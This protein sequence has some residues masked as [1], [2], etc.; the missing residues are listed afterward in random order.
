MTEMLEAPAAGAREPIAPVAT[1]TWTGEFKALLALG[2][3]LIISQLAQN[4]LHTTD[5]DVGLNRMWLDEAFLQIVNRGLDQPC[6]PYDPDA[7][8]SAND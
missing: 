6:I 7:K 8:E 4:A 3:P 1:R 5:E 2:W